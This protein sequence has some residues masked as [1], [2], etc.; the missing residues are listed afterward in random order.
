MNKSRPYKSVKGATVTLTDREIKSYIKTVN[1]WTDKEYK[2]QYDLFKNKL[3]TYEAFTG[4]P[5]SKAQS[6]ATLMYFEARSKQQLGVEYKPSPEL[7]RIKSFSAIG[8]PKARERALQSKATTRRLGDI[9]SAGTSKQFAGLINSNEK[10][11][12]IAENVKDSI[13]REEALKNYANYIN[14]QIK[15]QD[16][17]LKSSAIHISPNETIGSDTE[18]DEFDYSDFLD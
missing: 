10:A 6:P 12:E 18:F 15:Q 1:N 2:K 16:E 17:A 5:V 7:E 4:V 11:R 13:K 9:Y 8:S 14:W 3:R